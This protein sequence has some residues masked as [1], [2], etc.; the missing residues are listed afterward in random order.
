MRSGL[1]LAALIA[2]PAMAQGPIV[3][4]WNAVAQPDH[5][6][7]VRAAAK[8]MLAQLRGRH[9]RLRRIESA[10]QQVVAGMNYHLTVR[11][12]NHRIWSATVWHK[13]D[14][15]YAVTEIQRAK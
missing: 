15:T 2:A 3:G 6:A 8:A 7:E 9:V 10:S 1:W 13:L 5:D 12:T 4:G 11:L 14:G